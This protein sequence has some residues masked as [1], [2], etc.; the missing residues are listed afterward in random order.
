MD[1]YKAAMEIWLVRYG[2]GSPPLHIKGRT[3]TPTAVVRRRDIIHYYLIVWQKR[4]QE[5]G[6]A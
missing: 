1:V 2:G 5:G 4:V 6:G 3:K